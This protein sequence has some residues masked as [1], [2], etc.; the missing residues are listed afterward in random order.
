MVRHAHTNS[1]SFP[2]PSPLHS[3]FFLLYILSIPYTPIIIIIIYTQNTHTPQ[4]MKILSNPSYSDI[5]AWLPHGKGFILL[6]KRMF[7]EEVLPKFFKQS[8]FASFTRKLNRWGFVRVTRG[9][10]M[11]AYYH[12]VRGTMKRTPREED[13]H[14]WNLCIEWNG[15]SIRN[16]TN[17]IMVSNT[18]FVLFRPTPR[19]FS[20]PYIYCR[21]W[22]S[23]LH[24]A[25]SSSVLE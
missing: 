14:T 25:T 1:L 19:I 15:M 3:P 13:M 10:E 12:K 17:P 7:A 11:G 18:T 20:S 23:T 5:I 24:G 2:S 21:G 8:K 22:G 16:T 9:P 4:L 6:Q